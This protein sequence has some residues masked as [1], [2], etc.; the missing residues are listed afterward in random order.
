MEVIKK[1]CTEVNPH[2]IYLLVP[3][4]LSKMVKEWI[5]TPRSLIKNLRPINQDC[6]KLTKVQKTIH[7]EA[8]FQLD[9]HC[10]SVFE[11]I[12]C[13]LKRV[14]DAYG[15][16]KEKGEELSKKYELRYAMVKSSL[17]KINGDFK[18]YFAELQESPEKLNEYAKLSE[19]DYIDAYEGFLT[20]PNGNKSPYALSTKLN[21]SVLLCDV[22]GKVDDA[23][24]M[25]QT[26]LKE[27]EV[28][29]V[30]D[31]IKDKG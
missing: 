21:H 9:K 3:D 10:K 16:L 18:R 15:A 23:I 1:C 6:S 28:H 5:S 12:S 7:D 29:L 11:T 25:A 22:F 2:C 8:V 20:L 17:L 27:T 24:Q 14:D 13:L 30:Q 31:D 19:K 26:V 4:T